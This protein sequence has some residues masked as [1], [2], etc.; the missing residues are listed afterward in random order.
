[1]SSA[2]RSP[3][4]AA[5]LTQ[6]PGRVQVEQLHLD[7][8]LESDEVRVGVRACGLCH[9]DLHMLQGTL[10]TALPTVLGH[11]IAGVVEA[12]GPGVDDLQVGA[13]VAACLSMFCGACAACRTG[14]TWLCEKRM[15]L[16][17]DGRPRPRWVRGDGEP[18]GQVA[19][20]GGLAETVIVHRNALVGIPDLL[21]F[22]RAALLGCAVV[23]GVGSVIRGAQVRAGETVVVIGAG[24]VGLNVIQGARLAG[25][26]RIVAV[27]LN[28]DKL[29]MATT[30]GATD[31]ADAGE[32]PVAAVLDLIGA[33]DHVF[34]VVGRTE[35]VIQALD[36]LRPGRTVWVV[37]I[38]PMGHE[39]N[40][41][42]TA[43]VFAAK[44]VK[45]LLMGA[46]RFTEDIPVLADLYL[47]GRLL[48]DELV[49]LRIPLDRVEDG[50]DQMRDGGIARAVVCFGDDAG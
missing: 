50:F 46:N 11:E 47:Q 38:P 37:G 20:L 29:K 22:D 5:V 14:D 45:G 35:T 25:A 31:V 15:G 10:P 40:L 26:R 41:P 48:L 12:V 27:D 17:R 36:M 43:L 13:R 23:T 21:P 33:A 34:D 39:F 9:S 18:V 19:N 4:S 7:N 30:F 1:M 16:G 8:T 42:G 44:G 6:A 32:D 49:S 3:V 2:E 28:P 24:G